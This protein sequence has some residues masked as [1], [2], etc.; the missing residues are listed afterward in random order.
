MVFFEG[1]GETI[2]LGLGD[3]TEDEAFSRR[4]LEGGLDS[5]WQPVCK[6]KGSFARYGG[7]PVRQIASKPTTNHAE[8]TGFPA[9]LGPPNSALLPFLGGRVPLLTNI[10]Y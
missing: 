5:S 8:V 9:C 6:P 4:I 3:R 7:C 2:T 10:D 1:D